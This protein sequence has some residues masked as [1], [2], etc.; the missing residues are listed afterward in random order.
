MEQ[1]G[2]LDAGWESLVLL[3]PDSWAVGSGV[4][5]DGAVEGRGVAPSV[6]CVV[7]ML[8]PGVGFLSLGSRYVWPMAGVKLGSEEAAASILVNDVTVESCMGLS[9]HASMVLSNV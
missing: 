7:W 3:L 9:T 5:V 8:D 6:V 4:L 1:G 2:T